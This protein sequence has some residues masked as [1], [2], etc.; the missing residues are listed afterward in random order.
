MQFRIGV[1]GATGYIGVPYRKEI[2]ESVNDTKIIAVC[3]RRQ[4]RL[5][6]AA[7]EDGAE[8]VT[9]N[10]QDV[11]EHS[12]VNLVLVLTPDAMHYEP[13]LACAEHGKHVVCEK[14]VGK[15]ISQAHAMWQAIQQRGLASYVPYW[16]RYVPIFRRAKEIVASGKLGDIRSVL[17]RWHNPRPNAM[18]FTWRDDASLSAAGSI[19]DVGS[20]AYDM[21]RFILEEEATRVLTHASVLMPEKPHLGDVDLQE[22]I[23]WGNS[24]SAAASKTGK[25]G[26]VPDYAQIGF[27]YPSGI[28][29]SIVLSHAS[30]LRKGFAPELELHGTLG[31]L[32]VD[33]IGRVLRFADSPEPAQQLEVVDDDGICN[34]FESFVFPALEAQVSRRSDAPQDQHPNLLDGLR[35]Q[36]FTDAALASSLRGEWVELAEFTPVH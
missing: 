12:D 8:L 19:A 6:L 30:Y 27:E 16:N 34:R 28:V 24:N 17:Y 2:R 36:S 18:P 23:E 4:D 26:S 29:G 32:S 31:S 11:V 7:A 15:D 21:L 33:R 13:V 22:A 35:V 20:H 3:A 9:Q 14:P 25:K 10:W 5:E 1:I